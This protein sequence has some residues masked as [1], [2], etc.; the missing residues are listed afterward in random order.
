[1]W[2]QLTDFVSDR[3]NALTASIVEVDERAEV[4][5]RKEGGIM[6]ARSINAGRIL[7]ILLA[8]AIVVSGSVYAEPEVRFGAAYISPG[9]RDTWNS[10]GRAD[11]GIVFWGGNVGLGVSVAYDRW[12]VKDEFA[13]FGNY[14][15]AA[16]SNVSGAATVIPIGASLFLRTGST[17]NVNLVLEAGLKGLLVA[18]DIDGTVGYYDGYGWAEAG[19]DMDIGNTSVGLLAADLQFGGDDKATFYIGAGCQFGGRSTSS[20]FGSEVGEVTFSGLI[21]RCGIASKL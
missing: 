13:A 11:V 5:L 7:W 14:Y 3:L 1:M 6:K 18:S 21:L 9:D 15:S 20:F 4:R 10:A 8:V 17:G 2:L 12:T 16:S 19:G